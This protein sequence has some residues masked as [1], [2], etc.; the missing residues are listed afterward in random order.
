MTVFELSGVLYRG[1]SKKLVILWSTTN[2]SKTVKIK[3]V[4]NWSPH[5]LLTFSLFAVRVIKPFNS[6]TDCTR[7]GTIRYTTAFLQSAVV[8]LTFNFT[9]SV[10]VLFIL[11]P[12]ILY[13]SFQ[14]CL[15]FILNWSKP[16]STGLSPSRNQNVSIVCHLP[17]AAF[18]TGA[19]PAVFT[20][21]LE[22][23]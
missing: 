4:R 10:R 22:K 3:V 15:S 7:S 13:K 8:G 18:K 5:I 19:R 17:R 9:P 20:A 23:A 2:G 11:T 21:L 16:P 1:A 12:D 14:H 6:A